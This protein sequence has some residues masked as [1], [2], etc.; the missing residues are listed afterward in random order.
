MK[1]YRLCGYVTVVQEESS[2]SNQPSTVELVIPVKTYCPCPSRVTVYKSRF[3]G[4][5]PTV[6]LL[7]GSSVRGTC[8]RGHP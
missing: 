1:Q 4:F 6:P 2:Q 7:R 8:I 5:V 3:R